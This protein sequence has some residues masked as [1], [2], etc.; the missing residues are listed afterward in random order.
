[1]KPS[2]LLLHAPSVYD[3]RKLAIMY[4]P[5]ADLVPSTPIFEMY[6]LG[7]TSIAEYLERN[8]FR[9]RIVNLAVKMLESDRFDVEKFV[10][11]NSA[12]AFGIDLHWLPHAHGS[13]ELAKIIKKHHPD[14][15]VILGGLSATYYSSEI[16]R[17]HGEIDYI[18]RGDSTE[19]PMLRLMEALTRR[20]TGK[21]PEGKAR[22][23]MTP[24]LTWR[25]GSRIRSNPLTNVPES[26]DDLMLDYSVVVKS[27]IRDLDI[28]SAQPVKGWLRYPIAGICHVRGCTQ[29]C[30]TCGGSAYAYRKFFNRNKPAFRSPAKIVDDIA[31]ILEF[32]KG[33]VYMIGDIR[34]GGRKRASQILSI[35]AKEKLGS[36]VV[37]EL[38]APAPEPF[39]REIA[40]SVKNF[41]ISISPE[42][43]DES[44][45]MQQGRD[46]TT[47]ALEDTVESALGHGA[48]RFDIFFMIGL[49]GQDY[50]CALGDVRYSE[51]LYKKFG[52]SGRLHAFTSPMAPFLDP[53]S[54]AFEEPERLGYRVLC[55]GFS[56]H[57]ARLTEPS[58][59]YILNY[60]TAQLSRSG[61]VEATYEAALGFNELRAKYGLTDR[62]QSERARRHICAA[63]SV[64]KKID[65]ARKA[66]RSAGKTL[67]DEIDQLSS[68]IL[69]SKRE[70]EWQ[71]D[72]I[73]LNIGNYVKYL[74]EVFRRR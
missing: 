22:L 71:S 10:K 73:N 6:P 15:P 62:T 27:S 30:V 65:E 2:L 38:F 56:D 13:I 39:I 23:E 48:G 17:E 5:V 55:R 43:H 58:W 53:G 51:R 31:G 14:T 35:M 59:K 41:N 29:N 36:Q 66:S 45:R 3:F 69:C 44:V 32:T 42:S 54:I 67:R 61:I 12:D 40:R 21:T 60:E 33:P 16:M 19:E 70:L 47:K 72:G 11:K 63:V 46:Y 68:E 64:M 34:L 28:S 74:L 20:G 37:F 1:M 24:N 57:R 18:V 4:G 25:E 26:L 49:P 8:G 52:K 7:F 50:G 9:T